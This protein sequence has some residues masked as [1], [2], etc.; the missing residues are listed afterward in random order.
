[1]ITAL[2]IGEDGRVT[3]TFNARPNQNYA[4]E[5]TRD[6]KFW[7]ELSDNESSDTGSVTYKD[8]ITVPSAARLHYR[9]VER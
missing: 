4:V 1:M 2:S 3:V 8:N 7:E 9:A 5:V 6:F